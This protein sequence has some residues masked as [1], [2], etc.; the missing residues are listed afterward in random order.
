M[1]TS[2]QERRGV[3]EKTERK[4]FYYETVDQIFLSAGTSVGKG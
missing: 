4:D 2:Q 3:L 1:H